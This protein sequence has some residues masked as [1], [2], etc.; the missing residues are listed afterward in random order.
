MGHLSFQLCKEN[1]TFHINRE[2]SH[3]SV[4]AMNDFKERKGQGSNDMEKYE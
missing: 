1:F 4:P 2:F 3:I